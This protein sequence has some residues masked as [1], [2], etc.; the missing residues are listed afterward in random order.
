MTIDALYPV[1]ATAPKTEICEKPAKTYKTTP[2][3]IFVF[4]FRT[5]FGGRKTRDFGMIY[6]S[7]DYAKKNEP[8]T[9]L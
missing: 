7:S 5:H 2:D 6:D 9:D 4:E 3:T 8:N 1:K